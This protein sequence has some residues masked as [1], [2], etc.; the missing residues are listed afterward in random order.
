MS[1]LISVSM[2]C[3]LFSFIW[4]WLI[5]QLWFKHKFMGQLFDSKNEINWFVFVLDEQML[6][7]T[8]SVFFIVLILFIQTFVSEVKCDVKKYRIKVC[9][10]LLVVLP[11]GAGSVGHSRSG[12]LWPPEASFLSRHRCHPDVFLNRQPWQLRWGFLFVVV[13]FKP[14]FSLHLV[15]AQLLHLVSDPENIPEKW[16]PEVKHFCPNVPIILVGN[17]KDLRN[18][19]H[20]RR[21]LAKMKQVG[22]AF[23]FWFF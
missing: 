2:L 13:V 16:T 23:T 14:M 9:W 8:S 1:S 22:K 7:L 10:T 6:V 15:H 21:E 17:K 4:I 19:E 11:G 12:G 20:T 18:D 5:V 3:S